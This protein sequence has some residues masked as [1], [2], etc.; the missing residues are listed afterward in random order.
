MVFKRIGLAYRAKKVVLGTDNII[1]GMKNHKVK[2]VVI[3][4]SA[5]LNTQKVIQDKAS[6]YHVDVVYVDEYKETLSK[7]VGKNNIKVIGIKDQGFKKL[8]IGE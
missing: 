4:T 3:A 5:S 2:L 6:F 7:A 1:A 8:I